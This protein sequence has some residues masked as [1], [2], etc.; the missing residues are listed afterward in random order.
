MLLRHVDR[1][2]HLQL[3]LIIDL[4]DGRFYDPQPLCSQHHIQHINLYLPPSSPS[5]SLSPSSSSPPPLAYTLTPAYLSTLFHVID[6]HLSHHPSATILLHDVYSFDLS[7]TLIGLYLV[8]Q[9]MNPSLAYQMVS[10]S[11]PPGITHPQLVRL[12]YEQGEEEVEWDLGVLERGKW[13][14]EGLTNWTWSGVGDRDEKRQRT[15]DALV[16]AEQKQQ[17]GGAEAVEEEKKEAAKPAGTIRR[18]QKK[19]PQP[20]AAAATSSSSSSPSASSSSAAVA[21]PASAKVSPSS[22]PFADLLAEAGV[23]PSSSSSTAGSSTALKRKA[24]APASGPPAPSFS[25]PS[26]SPSLPQSSLPVQ[27]QHSYLVPVKMPHL[28]RLLSTLIALILT[29]SSHYSSF[30]LLTSSDL[31][32]KLVML[33][34][35]HDRQPLTRPILD[36]A[37]AQPSHYVLSWTPLA[38]QCLVL[39]LKEGT[40]LHFPFSPAPSPTL[41]TLPPLYHVPH[42]SFPTRSSPQ[43]L[44]THTVASA[45]LLFDV[46]P[47]VPPTPRLLLTDLLSSPSHHPLPPSISPTHRYR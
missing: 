46:L 24:P 1:T 33:W 4:T 20:L 43:Q 47:S 5:P 7:L 27:Q 17:P 38:H 12:L 37:R 30:P 6:S 15:D 34:S 29:P 23:M 18:K 21:V 40:F 28:Q 32:A 10:A 25:L 9:S 26:P 44:I 45:V 22:D 2:L 39:I 42:L 19:E 36:Q 14:G 13:M 41:A 3:G 11:R 35:W 16:Q 31:R 8:H